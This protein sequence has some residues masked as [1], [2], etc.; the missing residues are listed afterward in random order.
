MIKETNSCPHFSTFTCWKT[1]GNGSLTYSLLTSSLPHKNAP[2]LRTAPYQELKSPHG[3]CQAD[4]LVWEDLSLFQSH[5]ICTPLFCLSTCASGLQP[6]PRLSE[7]HTPLVGVILL[8]HKRCA[9]R[10]LAVS[11]GDPLA[12]GDGHPLPDLVL[13]G[14]FSMWVKALLH[15][16]LESIVFSSVSLIPR[17]SG[18]KWTPIPPAWH[19]GDLC[20]PPC[21]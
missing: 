1:A 10:L 3:L 20:Y 11:C 9:Y 14:L 19:T 6:H 13:L 18:Q 16:V 21:S 7:C 8:P 4:C 17:C 5:T 2:W 15:P 12:K